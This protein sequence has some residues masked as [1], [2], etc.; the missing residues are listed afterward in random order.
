MNKPKSKSAG[1]VA[2]KLIMDTN[3]RLQESSQQLFMLKRELEKKNGELETARQ[4]EHKQN[5]QLRR[6]L[7]SLKYLAGVKSDDKRHGETEDVPEKKL[8]SAI[9]EDLSLRY[10]NLLETYVTTKDL[11]INDS[12]FEEL[13]GKFLESGITPK[14]II[15]MHLKTVPQIKTIGDLETKRMAYESRMVLLK[16]MTHYASLLL[17]KNKED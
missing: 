3:R 6:E 9:A 2:G 4:R 8:T 7:S 1:R 11:K 16:V 10:I 12:L 17:K 13:C 14:G 5:E 15:T